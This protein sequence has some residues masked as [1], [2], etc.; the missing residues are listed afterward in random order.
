VLNKIAENAKM[1]RS[2]LSERRQPELVWW[3]KEK[4]KEL[5]TLSRSLPEKIRRKP[6]MTK[7]ELVREVSELRAQSEEQQKKELRTVV[8][9]FFADNLLDKQATLAKKNRQ[10]RD[11]KHKLNQK[12]ERLE[13]ILRDQE[14]Q[15]STLLQKMTPA[16]RLEVGS[17]QP[18]PTGRDKNGK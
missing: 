4:N 10:L 11:E 14:Q 13:T 18:A 16:Q 6:G 9:S 2:N 1:D 8:E 5:E 7:K 17:L 15:I 3:I 12:V